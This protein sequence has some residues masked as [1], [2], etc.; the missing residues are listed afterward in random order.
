MNILLGKNILIISPEP[1]GISLLSKHH[2]AIALAKRGNKV[3]FL[4]PHSDDSLIYQ[5]MKDLSL[6]V[7]KDSRSVRGLRF[8]PGF[9]RRFKMKQG[10]RML[11]KKAGVR[12][13]V[14]WSFD[15]SRYFDLNSFGTALKIFQMMDY[16]YDFN[17]KR[18]TSSASLCLGVTKGIIE[19]MLPYKKNCYFVQHGWAPFEI[20]EG[21]LPIGRGQYKAFYAGNLLLQFLDRILILRLV[22]QFPNVDFYFAGSYGNGNL[23]AEAP[24][25]LVEMIESLAK[26]ENVFLLGEIPPNELQNV[27]ASADVMLLLYDHKKY[28]NE[29]SNSHKI[30]Q[31]LATGKV[32]L[33]NYTSEYAKS[34]LLEMASDRDEYLYKF[35]Q[36][37]QDLHHFNSTD[38]SVKR[39]LYAKDHTY[40]RQLD[41]IEDI[42]AKFLS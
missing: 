19:K 14:I 17:L 38:R 10:I 2:Y 22:E 41:R 18:I 39:K 11:E 31:Y 16:N 35:D 1:W 34:E 24:R 20:G 5:P 8:F 36:I 37:L 7:L 15:S 12:F 26:R 33:A 6:F 30:M 40:D 23:N 42:L 4:T 25:E 28:P 27:M 21:S 29:V 13:D 32:V 9:W 3:W